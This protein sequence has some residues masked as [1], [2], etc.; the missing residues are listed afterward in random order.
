MRDGLTY[1]PAQLG[2]GGFHIAGPKQTCVRHKS[3]RAGAGTVG[4]GL[5]V[6]ASVPTNAVPGPYG[7]PRRLSEAGLRHRSPLLH[8]LRKSP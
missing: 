6:D 7:R 3:I 8:R 2:D 5:V 4:I 1:N